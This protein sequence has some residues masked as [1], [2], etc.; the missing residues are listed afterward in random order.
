MQEQAHAA[1]FLEKST[2]L[3]EVGATCS[4]DSVRRGVWLGRYICQRVTQVSQGELSEDRN[5]A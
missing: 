1:S 4:D 3:S 5:L 2:G